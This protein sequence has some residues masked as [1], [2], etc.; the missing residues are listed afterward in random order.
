M[1]CVAHGWEPTGYP[2]QQAL[3]AKGWTLRTATTPLG[4]GKDSEDSR[5]RRPQAELLTAPLDAQG[6]ILAEG[7][8]RSLRLDRLGRIRRPRPGERPVLPRGLGVR[9]WRPCSANSQGDW[10]S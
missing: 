3:R 10:A 1:G 6:R 7:S 5:S 4:T 8:L 2:D 9:L